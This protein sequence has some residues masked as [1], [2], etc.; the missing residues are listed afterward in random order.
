MDLEILNREQTT[1]STSESPSSA[2]QAHVPQRFFLW[3]GTWNPLPPKTR[4]YP[5]AIAASSFN[6]EDVRAMAPRQLRNKQCC[7]SFIDLSCR[8]VLPETH[9]L[10][11]P[12]PPGYS[13][14]SRLD[15]PR[16]TPPSPFCGFR[17]CA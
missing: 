4:P 5:Q 10:R 13:V 9:H 14:S 3:K 16:L 12:N 1:R 11:A 6:F 17:F 2:Q 15:F 8:I 7:K